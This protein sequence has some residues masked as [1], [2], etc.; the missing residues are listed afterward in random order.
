M[1]LLSRTQKILNAIVEEY[2]TSAKPVSSNQI[3]V[4]FDISPATVRNEMAKLEKQNLI[5]QPHTSAGRIPTDEAYRFYISCLHKELLAEKVR[6]LLLKKLSS[7]PNY[8]E[9]VR[10]ATR[11]LAEISGNIAI[12]RPSAQRGIYYAGLANALKQP[13]SLDLD[14]TTAIGEIIDYINDNAGELAATCVDDSIEIYIGRQNP[15]YSY[16][17]CSLIIS[18]FEN[19]IGE[20]SF[21]G[22]LGPKR[23]NYQRIIPVIKYISRIL[24]EIS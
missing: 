22:V 18:G 13:E 20:Q 12:C 11:M 4:R 3:A 5:T 16:D 9:L 1:Q 21:I 19:P 6:N 2:I 14:F 8:D 23:M 10:S 17:S 24:E 15:F 7:I